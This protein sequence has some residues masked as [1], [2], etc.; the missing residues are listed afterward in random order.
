[1]KNWGF[2]TSLRDFTFPN[3]VVEEVLSTLSV[4]LHDL[5]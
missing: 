3:I 5:A 1:M 2:F 4:E